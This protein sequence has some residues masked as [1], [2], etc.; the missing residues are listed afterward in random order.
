M[1]EPSN[2]GGDRPVTVSERSG[3]AAMRVGMV[4]AVSNAQTVPPSCV[5]RRPTRGAYPAR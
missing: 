5:R 2:P 4:M 3:F 1:I